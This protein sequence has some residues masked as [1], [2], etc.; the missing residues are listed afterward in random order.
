MLRVAVLF[1]VILL[2]QSVFAQTKKQS[3][4]LQGDLQHAP[5]A[6]LLFVTHEK[7]EQEIDTIMTDGNGH[8]SYSTADI[9]QPI[10]AR[11]IKPGSFSTDLF[12]A[13]GYD[14]TITG[15]AADYGTFISSKK[16]T[17]KGAA[18]N[19]YIVLKDS[20]QFVRKDTPEWYNL[21]AEQL[22]SYIKRDKAFKDSIQKKAFTDKKGDDRWQA[23]YAN[24]VKMD[25]SFLHLYYLIVQ[26]NYNKTFSYEQMVSYIRNNFNNA[27][28]DDIFNDKYSISPN[29]RTWLMHEYGNYLKR[30]H[31]A[32]DSS[33]CKSG[34]EREQ[35]FKIIATAF[36]GKMRERALFGNLKGA[37]QFSRSFEE[38]NQL[39]AE[40]PQY[41]TLL[42]NKADQDR[43]SG[44]FN[45]M[46]KT[47]LATQI[48]SPAP[49]F[50]A[51]DS[52]GKT[53]SLEDFKGKVIYLDLWASWCGPCRA[54][55]PHFKKIYDKYKNDNRVVFMGVAVSDKNDKW[56]EAL[57]EDGAQW[58]QLFDSNGKVQNAYVANSIPK[59]VLINKQGNIVSFDAPMP[60]S[61]TELEKLLDQEMAK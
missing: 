2:G 34:S 46:E 7:N 27:V 21:N 42:K 48:G 4:A 5:S 16:V 30:L 58:L 54:E 1:S 57:R 24:L 19:R 23:Y 37:I 8:F 45:E 56:L 33:F 52:S 12:A 49:L 31:C 6:E 11:L 20:L 25:E 40:L 13:P 32:K 18:S 35:L 50:S 10:V 29:Y 26:A 61:G 51:V 53:H 41:I 47:L 38:L 9:N 55:T 44:L 28:L 36:K 17:G 15:D 39:K 60:S 59:F 14:L 22:L 43:V 3:F